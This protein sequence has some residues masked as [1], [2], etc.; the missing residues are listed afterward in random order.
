MKHACILDSHVLP[1]RMHKSF[2]K[3][4]RLIFKSIS[5]S[6]NQYGDVY[7]LMIIDGYL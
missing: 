4:Q 6:F 1:C 7:L 2:L 3:N 5:T